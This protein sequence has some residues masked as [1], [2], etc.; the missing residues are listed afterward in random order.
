M[1]LTRLALL[2]SFTLISSCSILPKSEPFDVYRLPSAQAQPPAAMGR[3][4]A[5]R[6]A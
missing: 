2:A 5:G 1:K 6:C 4:S 3:R